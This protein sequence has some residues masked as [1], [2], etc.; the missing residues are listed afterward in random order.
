MAGGERARELL[1]QENQSSGDVT[2]FSDELSNSARKGQNN[3]LDGYTASTDD[4]AIASGTIGGIAYS[5]YM[6][7]DSADGVSNQTDS[8]KKVMLT[9]VATKSS[10]N[11]KAVVQT[12]VQL[13]TGVTSPATIYSKGDVT[14]NGSSLTIKGDDECGAETDLAPVYTKSPAITNL[15]GNP[16]LTGSPSTPQTGNLD[17]GIA[18]MIS[19]LKGSAQYTLTEDTNN[20][21]FG[22]SN[23]YKVVYSNT[24]SP[25]NV[26]GLKL[27]NLTGYGIL[28]VDGDLELGGGFTWYGPIVVTGSVTLNGG[29]GVGINIHGQILS[30]TSTL[31][32]VTLNGGNVIQYNSCEL[33][34]AFATQPL[35]VLNWKQNLY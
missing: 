17:L 14:G 27:N 10:D 11:S 19:S 5:A 20:A 31:T 13:Y 2:T 28:L 8:N 15:S 26:N 12:V 3:T 21:T 34:K 29:G 4:T 18:A 1:R 7:N 33:K 6:S 24:S 25:A 23:S 9:T 35:V 30:G 22:N 16:T 32:D